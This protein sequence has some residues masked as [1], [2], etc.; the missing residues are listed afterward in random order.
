MKQNGVI[1]KT[2]F[3][4]NRKIVQLSSFAAEFTGDDNT[5]QP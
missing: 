1:K 2:T 4:V 3:K 5:N